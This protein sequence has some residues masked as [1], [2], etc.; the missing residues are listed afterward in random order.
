VRHFAS[1]SGLVAV[2]S[3]A[4]LVLSGTPTVSAAARSAPVWTTASYT[5]IPVRETGTVNT[6]ADGDTFR[7]IPD[8]ANGYVTVRLLG[9]NTPEVRGFLGAN[10]DRD[11]CGGP[12]ASTVLASLLPAGSRVQLRSVI[13]NST[14]EDGRWRRYAFAW[15]EQTGQFDIDVQASMAAAGFAMWFPTAGETTLSYQYR[16]LIEQA[17]QAGRAIWDPTYCGPVEQP[18]A[19]VSLVVI[20]DAPGNDNLNINGEQIIVRNIGSVPVDLSGWLLRDSSNTS[21]FTMPKGSVLAPN[22]FRVVHVGTGTNG[23][24]K[25]RDLYMNST[26][27]LFSNTS[28]SFFMGDGAYLLDPSTSIRSY[29][30][31]PCVLDCSDSLRG[32]VRIRTVQPIQTSSKPRIAANQEYVVIVNRSSS[33]VLLD[34]YYLRYRT[35]TYP[36]IPNT[37][38]APG[39]RLTV[40]MG[41]GTPTRKTQ[42]W[43]R[44]RPL[45]TNGGGVIRL[46]SPTNVLVSQKKW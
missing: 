33:P 6:V 5:D 31:Y 8:G 34:G 42:Y 4:L 30:Q 46:L 13:P 44:A 7:F 14:G 29:F 2:S 28:T 36:F 9:I 27:A 40:R 35:S 41:Q 18:D 32:I 12:E 3:A 26:R 10:F 21:W 1:L 38:I 25:P 45:L 15:N 23:S 39:G 37:R 17:Q 19:R 43:G 11:M 16:V 24:P 22:D 20:W